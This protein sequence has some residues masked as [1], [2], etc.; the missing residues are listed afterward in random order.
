[1]VARAARAG[2]ATGLVGTAFLLTL[3]GAIANP[4]DEPASTP[5]ATSVRLA[6]RSQVDARCAGARGQAVVRAVDGTTRTVSFKH[7]WKVYQGERP[8]TL[9]TVCPD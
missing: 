2:L 4:G 8:G 3:G 9:V 5:G 7:G 6:E 1:M